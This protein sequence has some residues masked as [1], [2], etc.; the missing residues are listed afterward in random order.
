MKDIVYWQK[1]VSE[2][3]TIKKEDLQKIFLEKIKVKKSN[4]SN[5]SH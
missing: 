5:Q 3:F 2:S 1:N 4:I